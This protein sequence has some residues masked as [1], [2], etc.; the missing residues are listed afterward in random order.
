MN[1]CTK[2]EPRVI[3]HQV[4][5]KCLEE[6]VLKGEA[7]RLALLEGIPWNEVLQARLEFL[8]ILRIDHVWMLPGLRK[9]SLSNNLIEKIEN[10]DALV[11]LEELDLSFNRI[12]ALENLNTLVNLQILTVFDNL[13]TKIENMDNLKKLMIFSIGNNL[14]EDRE[15]VIYLRRFPNL[16]SVNMA[17]NP[18][19]KEADFRIF[20][21]VFLHTVDYYEYKKILDEEREEGHSI[22]HSLLSEIEE[23]E[24][25]QKEIDDKIA[26]ENAESELYADS[27]IEFLGSNHL[28]DQMFE[29]DVDLQS[30]MKIGDDPKDFYTEL[31]TAFLTYCLQIFNFG[32]E[33]YKI[34]HKEVENFMKNVNAAKKKS[35]QESI[36]QMEQFIVKK[37][38]IFSTIKKLQE[39]V[40]NRELTI[41]DYNQKVFD[42]GEQYSLLIHETWKTLMGLEM[43]VYEQM[44]DV[45]QIFEQAL[46]EMINT[47]IEYAQG[48]FAQMRT[49]EQT[50]TENINDCAQR[51]MTMTSLTPDFV[52]PKELKTLMSDKDI[53][54][55]SLG[56]SHDMHLLAI[57]NREDRLVNRAKNWLNGLVSNL[58]KDEI[59][60]NRT[61]VLEINNY[62]DKQRE[63][64]DQLAALEVGPPVDPDITAALS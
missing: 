59:I 62:L 19:A 11:N 39:D 15:N 18:C 1:P 10:M 17:G 52:M 54:T 6:Q 51:Y 24:A 21:C 3:D 47:F 5:Q 40:D 26:A 37:N 45:N 41:A 38:K 33:Q 7:G 35:Q 34:R 20:A 48:V 31:E 27:F 63:E 29:E 57:D 36:D 8:N 4:I 28:F 13:I 9:L 14:I 25:K 32:Q 23:V 56:A 58:A 60:R 30:L 50:Y 49:A 12:K 16:K 44:E 53:L 43:V 46:T 55:N 64:F 2:S 22:Y 42:Y 61:K